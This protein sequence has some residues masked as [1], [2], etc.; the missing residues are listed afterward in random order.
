MSGFI[1]PRYFDNNPVMFSSV[2]GSVLDQ[3]LSVTLKSMET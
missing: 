1:Y 3:S 2:I